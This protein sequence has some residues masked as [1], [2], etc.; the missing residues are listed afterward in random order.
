MDVVAMLESFEGEKGRARRV[1]AIAR[2]L[3]VAGNQ[4]L[5]EE[6]AAAVELR[7][8]PAGATLIAQA[9][10]DADLFLI[11]EGEFQVLVD[12]AVVAK[13]GAGEHVGEIAAIQPALLRTATVVARS[14]AVVGKLTEAALADLGDRYPSVYKAIAQQLAGRLMQRNKPAG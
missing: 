4:A 2:Q 8:V 7:A 10:G 5:A 12:G 1:E 3:L 9:D 11:L 14:D 13:R 6:I